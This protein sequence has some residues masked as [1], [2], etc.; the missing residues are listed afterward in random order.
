M[1][2]PKMDTITT[3]VTLMITDKDMVT[4]KKMRILETRINIKVQSNIVT[5]LKLQKVTHSRGRKS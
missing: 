5:Y 4:T 3:M 1:L 2:N